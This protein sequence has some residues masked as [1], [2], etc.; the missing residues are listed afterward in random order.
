MWGNHQPPFGGY[1]WVPGPPPGNFTAQAPT[2]EHKPMSLK[3]QLKKLEQDRKD[4]D[5]YIE[6]L[7][8]MSK[9]KDKDKKDKENK[10]SILQLSMLMMMTTPILAFAELYI[11]MKLFR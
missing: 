9:D 11:Y 3:K 6:N 7:K 4:L 8:K 10:L 1:Y 5:E 2:S